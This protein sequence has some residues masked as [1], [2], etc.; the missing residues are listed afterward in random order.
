MKLCK[1]QKALEAFMLGEEVHLAVFAFQAS[2]GLWTLE[3]IPSAIA[4]SRNDL[5]LTAFALNELDSTLLPR[6]LVRWKCFYSELRAML[7]HFGLKNDLAKTF[8]SIDGLHKLGM[9]TKE[10]KTEKLSSIMLQYQQGQKIILKK[11][12]PILMQ[13][14]FEQSL[15]MIQEVLESN[16]VILDFTVL[17]N[18]PVDV[19][20]PGTCQITGILL[21]VPHKGN[22]IVELANFNELGSLSREWS[23]KLNQVIKFLGTNKQ[24]EYQ[25]EADKIG[26]R[27]REMLF[28]FSMESVI[29]SE[30]VT[31][32][33]ICPD[34]PLSNLPLDLLPWTN[35]KYLFEQCSISYLSCCREV[36]REWC[37]QTIQTQAS[38]EENRDNPVHGDDTESKSTMERN[39]I[40][41][42]VN[43]DCVIF[44]DPDYDLQLNSDKES[45]WE[46]LKQNL[47]PISKVHTKKVNR[48]LKSLQ[49]ADE[50]KYLFS[51]ANSGVVKPITYLG[52]NATIFEALRVK[53]PLVL[54]FSTHG[55]SQPSG[56]NSYGGNFWT[57]MTTGLAL[58]GINTYRFGETSKVVPGAGTGELTA[59]AVCGMNLRH[60][61]LVYLST[62]VSSVGFAT[63]GESVG[64]LSQA[65]RAAG[66]ETVVATLWPVMDDAARKFAIYFYNALSKPQTKPSEA[67]NQARQELRQ[68][69]GFEHWYYW[70]PF[71]CIGYNLPLFL[72]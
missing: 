47:A 39:P 38:C 7:I 16:E 71:V 6:V 51:I 13:L 62:C 57:D 45:L 33:Y 30:T 10:A 34:F 26:K 19:D 21:L 17:A 37:F 60:T 18:T 41:N 22:F 2:R 54:H 20:K 5:F 43:T 42:S 61:R 65:F 72:V 52:K 48:L 35:G 3:E 27:I 28:P 44:A 23:E 67:I 64:S 55:F 40:T 36:L 4:T 9:A 59:M 56:G 29:N 32:L 58:A 63:I 12:G 1:P 69:A 68:E 46:I 31:C 49:E 50:V 11:W 15:Q 66:A 70:G 53:S 25:Q 14:L 8:E 24:A